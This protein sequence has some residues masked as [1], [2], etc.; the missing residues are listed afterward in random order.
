MCCNIDVKSATAE[1]HLQ[2]V[3]VYL[4]VC[5][6]YGPT[7]WRHPSN[8]LAMPKSSQQFLPINTPRE[9]YDASATNM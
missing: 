3:P 4:E 7:L 6:L 5:S 1:V 2:I 8:A 9:R